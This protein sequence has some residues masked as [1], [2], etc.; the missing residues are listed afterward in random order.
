[1]TSRGS[2]AKP[3][4]TAIVLRKAKSLI[5]WV[6]VCM[7][8]SPTNSV[9]SGVTPSQEPKQPKSSALRIKQTKTKQAC[10][11]IPPM[12]K[13]SVFLWHPRA[14]RNQQNQPGQNRKNAHQPNPNQQSPSKRCCRLDEYSELRITRSWLRRATDYH[15]E[16]SPSPHPIVNVWSDRRK[17]KKTRSRVGVDLPLLG[18]FGRGPS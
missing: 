13:P 8:L 2:P 18:F 9:P 1:M 7:T 14:N 4:R 16:N 11:S 10:S 15:V 6:G 5:K 3:F 17:Q 12:P